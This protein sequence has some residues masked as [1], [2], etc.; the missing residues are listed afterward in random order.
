MGGA[1]TVSIG[2]QSIA[3]VWPG[4]K[5]PVSP[6]FGLKYW[7]VLV[8]EI[9]TPVDGVVCG[10]VVGP[11]LAGVEALP[12]SPKIGVKLYL[13]VGPDAEVELFSAF[14]FGAVEVLPG[15][16]TALVAG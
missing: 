6:V 1:G 4:V 16:G 10:V 12:E 8:I 14:G 2:V 5:V 7:P 15:T 13:L 3:G 11:E 9:R